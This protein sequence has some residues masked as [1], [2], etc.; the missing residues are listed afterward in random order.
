MRMD[1]RSFVAAGVAGI[2]GTSRWDAASRSEGG[3]R[4]AGLGPGLRHGLTAPPQA[5]TSVLVRR[6]LVYDG[7]GAPPVEADLA[8]AGDRI[9][10]I[11]APGRLAAPRDAVLLDARDLAVAPGFVD[12]HSHTDLELFSAPRAESKVRQGVTTEITGQDG[13]SYGPLQPERARELAERIRQE[14]GEA[15]RFGSVADFLASLEGRRFAVNLATMVGHGTVRAYVMGDEDRRASAE[16]VARMAALVREALA[17]GA[18]GLSTGLEYIPGAFADL[19]ELVT[20]ARELAGS[21]LPYATH[22][23]NEDDGLFAAIEEAINVGRRAG[24]PVQISHLKAQGRRNWWKA[25]PVLALLERAW[26]DGVDVRYDRYPYVAY[27]TGL[28]SLFPPWTREG[29]TDAFL[30]RLDDP[31]AAPRIEQAVREKVALLG[32]WDAVLVSGTGADSLAWLRGRRLGSAAAERGED[33]YALLR[34][35]MRADRA[36]SGM[37]GFGMSESNTERFLA[38]PFGMVSSDGSALPAEGPLAAGAPH[39]RNYGTFP[40]VLGRYV[41]ERGLLPLETAIHKM[42]QMP[43]QRVR[44]RD[45]GVLAPG[46]FADVVVFDPRTVGDR[47]TFEEPRQ[48]PVGMLHVLVNGVHVV[49]D[50][51]HTGALPGR[52]LRRTAG[53]AGGTR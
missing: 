12:I 23:R 15:V 37:V 34:Y 2:A 14:T 19:D 8:I 39:P 17:A 6:G 3:P 51:E 32:D 38:H 30:A 41:R 33:P 4:P 48:Y 22:M 47:A 16:E 26:G 29:G 21:G 43:A 18:V 11:A 9:A 40:R 20:L 10:A 7:T 45:R 27:S 25:E 5:R 50:G 46:A 44:L 24:V 31:E 36:R 28:S 52:V 53:S 13:S 49:R 42:T 35:V 1:R